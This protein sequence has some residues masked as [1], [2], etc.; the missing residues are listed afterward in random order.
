MML[1][2][3]LPH[4]LA[5]KLWPP[6]TQLFFEGLAQRF[7]I[8]VFAKDQRDNQPVIART[9][10][11][12][13]T[14]VTIKSARRPTRNVGRSPC[15]IAHLGTKTGGVML[16]IACAEQAAARDRLADQPDNSAIHD[17]L[18][19]DGKITDGKFLLG[20]YLGGRHILLPGK[21]EGLPS[22]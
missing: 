17:D 15:V 6:V 18:V 22:G 13:R 9:D 1:C 4:L 8:A 7:N 19:S 11:A 14:M 2:N 10:L 16:H 5:V 20:G 21:G 12:I 3:Q